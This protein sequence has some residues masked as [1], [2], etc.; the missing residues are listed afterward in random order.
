MTTIFGVENYHKKMD[1]IANFFDGCEPIDSVNIARLSD[2]CG[3]FDHLERI[4]DSIM[5]SVDPL[6]EET[7]NHK[8][9]EEA[10]KRRNKAIEI[11]LIYRKVKS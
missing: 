4:C 8:E 1:F 10:M 5:C 6:D 9:W 11:I 2:Y 3:G 7:W